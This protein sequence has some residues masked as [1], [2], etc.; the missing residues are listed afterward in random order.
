[1]T[2]E[3]RQIRELLANPGF[4]TDQLSRGRI[5]A[6][7]LRDMTPDGSL[8]PDA[9]GLMRRQL[10]DQM[11]MDMKLKGAAEFGPFRVP[12]EGRP[13]DVAYADADR[14]AATALRNERGRVANEIARWRASPSAPDYTDERLR[15]A[16]AIGMPADPDDFDALAQQDAD[17]LFNKGRMEGHPIPYGDAEIVARDRLMREQAAAM[18]GPGPVGDQ[19][20]LFGEKT[21]VTLEGQKYDPPPED[22]R[23]GLFMAP[24]HPSVKGEVKGAEHQ[25]PPSPR[26]MMAPPRAAPLAPPADTS[27]PSYSDEA[28][29]VRDAA[30]R[31]LAKR[32]S[33]TKR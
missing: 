16:M 14:V 11:F 33:Q 19:E 8:D 29:A 6:A 15:E 5:S 3:E 24:S 26:R 2:E 31:A 18:D 32:R 12:S 13:E 30:A 23:L 22:F 9:A 17:A 21:V 25:P 4:P 28:A 27:A 1:M 20:N 7:M 10:A